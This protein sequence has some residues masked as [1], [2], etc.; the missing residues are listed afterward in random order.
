MRD[1]PFYEDGAATVF[2][3]RDSRDSSI[4]AAKVYKDIGPVSVQKFRKSVELLLT[5]RGRFSEQGERVEGSQNLDI[6]L[7]Q[8]KAQ[9]N[10]SDFAAAHS[11]ITHMDFRR[12]FVELISFSHDTEWNPSVDLETGTLFIIME[13][14]EMSLRQRMTECIHAK[15]CLQVDE[16]QQIHWTLVSA[17]CGLHTEGYMH[18]DVK[19]STV[20]SY[21][22]S[23]G[24]E[25]W[26]LIDL[27]GVVRSGAQMRLSE[28][29]HAPEYAPPD[30]AQLYLRSQREGGRIILD[31]K[32]NVWSAGMCALEALSLMPVFDVKYSWFQKWQQN[33]GGATSFMAT[34]AG[35]RG[36]LGTEKMIP[37]DMFEAMQRTNPDMAQMIE[38]MLVKESKQR[39]TITQC[40]MH[41]WFEPKRKAVFNARWGVEE[42]SEEDDEIGVDGKRKRKP[43]YVD[44]DDPLL[45]EQV[46]EDF[47]AYIKAQ[48]GRDV[49][50]PA[51]PINKASDVP[52][53]ALE[54][55]AALP[56]EDRKKNGCIVM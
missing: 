24:K 7:E 27:D 17:V 6:I 22:N 8:L 3:A 32:M 38:G 52:P 50:A 26:K 43:R 30:L 56:V 33:K 41:K 21:K 4:V 16:I 18:L 9:I 44:E 28:I 55:P 46:P 54:S 1:K 20:F 19:P 15:S 40:L 29:P 49:A 51:E 42:D 14:G 5:F 47:H 11:F 23:R 10:L 31:R 35:E 2:R 12:C 45:D 36:N 34:L 25:V 48:L 37:P 13:A 39:A 53:P